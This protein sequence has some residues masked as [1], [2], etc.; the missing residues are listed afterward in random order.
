VSRTG[1]DHTFRYPELAN[2]ARFVN[3]LQAVIDGEIV[4]PDGEGRPSF[5]R[6]QQRMNLSAPRDIERARSKVPVVL[7]VFDLLW[8]DGRDLT[9]QPLE[10][11]T[12]LL[13]GIV[14]ETG[15]V[16]RV[17]TVDEHGRAFFDKAKELGF[18]GVVAKRRGAP[19][20]QGRR[21]KDWR[22]I[23]RELRRQG[24]T[25]RQTKKGTM[26]L[27]PDG[28]GKVTVHRTPS[29]HRALANV[30]AQLRAAGFRWPPE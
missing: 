27:A 25:A 13:D 21:S 2:L 16:R 7:F 1:R 29:D 18:E 22:K 26:W 3:A 20:L 24:W 15:P 14:T 19:Y 28:V 9:A 10:E 23:E 30:L 8:L 11:R 6:L 12:T 17:V 5:E 4:A